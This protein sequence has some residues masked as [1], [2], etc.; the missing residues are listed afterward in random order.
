VYALYGK[1]DLLRSHVNYDPGDHNFG[2][3]NRQA[4]YR[5]LGDHFFA[6]DPAFNA[7]EI[8]CDAEVKAHTNL[9]VSIPTN[10]ATFNSL[11][12]ALAKDLPHQPKLPT[13]KADAE[14]WQKAN[15]STLR[16]VIRARPAHAAAEQVSFEEQAGTK[17]TFWRIKVDDAWT[18]PAVELIRGESSGTVLLV[19]DGGRASVVTETEQLLS[20]GKLVLALDPFYFGESRIRSHDSLFALLVAAVG[21]RA[22]GVQGSQLA[23]IARWSDTARQS[24]PVKL[25]AVGPRSSLFALVAAALEEKSISA[26]ELRGSLGSLKEVLEQNWSVNQ[27]PEMFCFGLLEA[28]DV[29]HLAAL[30]APR[31]VTFAGASDR[32]RNELKEMSGWYR[33]LG[34]EF[35]PVP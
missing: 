3:D 29:K 25:L 28:F 7:T 18:V 31:P 11:A 32:A 30:V 16:E 14:K 19:A 5:M 26:V 34:T 9:L 12:R 4:F 35:E 24:G 6:G 33:T 20:E 23:A 8:P 17:A 22:L 15:R 27:K 1:A 13:R 2:Q 10:N 21:D